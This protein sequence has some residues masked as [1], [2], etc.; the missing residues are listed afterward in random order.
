MKLRVPGVVGILATTLLLTTILIGWLQR[1]ALAASHKPTQVVIRAVLY[2]GYA[3]GDADEA[4][5]LQNNIF[6]TT[7]IAGWQINDGSS[8]QVR[9]PAGTQLTPWQTIWVARDGAAFQTHFGFAPDFETI[10]SSLAIPDMEGSWP[11][12]ANSGDEVM[13]K[14]D[15][16]FLIDLLLYEG[17]LTPQLGWSGPAVQPYQVNGLFAAEGQILQRKVEPASNQ[18]FPDTDTAA[19]WIQDPDDP[20]WGKQVRYPGWDSEQ[21][22]NTVPI[23]SSAALTVAIAPDNSYELVVAEINR[24]AHSIQAESLTF[25][26]VGIA[27]AL[28]AAAQRGVTVTLLLEGGPA[29]G[30]TDQERYVCQQLD[31]AGGA[32]WFMI[33]DPAHDI[34]DR[35]RFLHA[36]FII[37]DGQR[38]LLSSENLSPRSLPDDRKDD[39][40]WGRRGVLFATDDPT[41]VAQLQLLFWD[42]FAPSQHQDLRR[43]TATDP[44]YGPPPPGFVP[45]TASGGITY[46][47]RFSAPV[48]FNGPLSLTLLQSPD[49]MLLPAS[50]L[51]AQVHAAGPGSVIRVMQL[52]ER[53]H[54]GPSDSNPEQDPNLRLEAYFAAARRGAQVR[55]LLDEYFTDLTDPSGNAATCAYVRAVASAERLDLD[56]RLGNPAGLGIHNKMILVANPSG[57]YAIVGSVN[58]TEL[59]HKG[60]REIALQVGSAAV[61]DYLAAMFDWDWPKQLHF[62]VVT[63]DYLGAADHLLIS[64]VLYDPA[65]PDDAEFIELVNPTNAVLDL[66]G[67]QL[68]DAVLPTDFEDNRLF[69]NGTMLPANETLVVATTAT[70]FQSKFGFPPDFE[71]LPTDPLVPDLIDDP[72]WGDPAAFLQLGNMGD[73]LILRSPAGNLVDLV[74]YG[75]GTYPGH[76]SCPLVTGFDH[77]LERFPYWRDRDNCSDD[78]RDW[79]FPNPGQ[80]P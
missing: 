21:F 41:L 72:A 56:C 50:G 53:P 78:F 22:Q 29:G 7:T 32:C 59:S 64:E 14:D 27:E 48:Q 43:W 13:L 28:V 65:G 40:T 35:Y 31:D 49:N 54:W 47:V 18:V 76:A 17:A 4:V 26:H 1:Q 60:N 38:V 67:Y 55:L 12:F 58:G 11:G 23:S 79:A 70:G 80:L 71:I 2:D 9:F 39:G 24:A 74:V 75:D 42:D 16:E 52:N 25:E 61:H 66:S 15:Q 5:Q 46:T 51:L 69:P 34:F 62:P 6:L 37:V 36:K 68:G 30:L 73:E 19:D 44:T 77:S 3:S 63:H 57:R 8:S 33:N 20:I 10:D 45:D